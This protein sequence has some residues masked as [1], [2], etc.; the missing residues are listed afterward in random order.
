[1][2]KDN[3]DYQ[4]Q[5]HNA[6]CWWK[7]YDLSNNVCEYEVNRLTNELLEENE[8]LM[9]IVYDARRPPN[10]IHQSVSLNFLRKNPA[11]NSR[12]VIQEC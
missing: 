7:G 3:V 8:T 9:H 10:W 1:M 2:L 11:K 4:G 6:T 5:G 12:S